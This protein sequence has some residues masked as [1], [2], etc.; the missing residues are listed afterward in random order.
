M[1]AGTTDSVPGVITAIRGI[2]LGAV[3]M[4]MKTRE[5]CTGR[6]WRPSLASEVRKGKGNAPEDEDSQ[7]QYRPPQP[8]EHMAKLE[9]TVLH[10][11]QRIKLA[12]LRWLPSGMMPHPLEIGGSR[13]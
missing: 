13:G 11:K 8:E 5:H 12:E 3:S 7:Q 4:S 1:D 10:S 9:H 2:N 6:S